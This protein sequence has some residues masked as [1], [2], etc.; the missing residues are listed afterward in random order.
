MT[1]FIVFTTLFHLICSSL[2]FFVWV[3]ILFPILLCALLMYDSILCKFLSC[4]TFLAILMFLAMLFMICFLNFGF[5]LFVYV[6]MCHVKL[7][8]S[9]TKISY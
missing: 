2:V 9:L 3:I 1:L 6:F 4:L 5:S 7:T 8:N